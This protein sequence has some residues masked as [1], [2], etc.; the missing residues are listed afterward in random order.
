MQ[1][2]RET[3]IEDL[4][5]YA[6][7]VIDIKALEAFYFDS[8]VAYLENLSE[9]ELIEYNEDYAEFEIEDYMEDR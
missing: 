6:C 2:D 1:L 3:L 7:D 4:A 5:R 8:Q 9:E